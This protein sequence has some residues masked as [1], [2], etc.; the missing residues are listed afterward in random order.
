MDFN[1]LRRAFNKQKSFSFEGTLLALDPGETTGATCF[2]CSKEDAVCCYGGQI[3]TWPL[4]EGIVAFSELLKN[5]NPT[6]VVF[7]SYQVY[8]WKTKDHTWSDIPT[9]QIIG[10]IKTL[11]IL[12]RI[13]FSTQ[14]AQV[15]KGFCDDAKLKEW[16]Y[17]LPGIRHARD[18]IRHACYYL[19]FGPSKD[20]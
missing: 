2:T 15:A 19:L 20:S 7:E 5:L 8:E 10:M 4:E 18:A 17:W 12:N 3:K 13:P 1:T 9:V 14:T 11:L 6:Q 16:G